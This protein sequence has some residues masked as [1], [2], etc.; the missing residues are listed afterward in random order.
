ME[1]MVTW[2]G[3]DDISLDKILETNDTFKG[4]HTSGRTGG[5]WSGRAWRSGLVVCS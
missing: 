3:N 2:E 4:I 5:I 1:F